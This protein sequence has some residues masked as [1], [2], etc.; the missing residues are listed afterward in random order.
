MLQKFK[1][2]LTSALVVAAVCTATAG[3][4]AAQELSGDVGLACQA[5]L[6]LSSATR[7][8]ECAASIARYFSISFRRWSDTLRGRINFLN[9]CPAGS[10]DAG[11]RSL[12]V[13]I[14]NGAGQCDLASLNAQ[15]SSD[16]YGNTIISNAMSGACP[17]LANHMYTDL[18]N[19]LPVYVGEPGR[20][21]YWVEPSQYPIALAEY[22]AR[23][24]AEDAA[25][26]GGYGGG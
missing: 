23:V 7:P 22:N 18:R 26:A 3:P 20:G 9:L 21:G 1:R 24:A 17:V 15:R 14:A 6:C 19:T 8:S 25:R 11:M 16:E 13:A 10:A 5:L 4:V 2:R 12:V